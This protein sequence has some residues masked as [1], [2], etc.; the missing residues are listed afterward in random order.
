MLQYKDTTL[1]FMWTGA[2][3]RK[4]YG[5]HYRKYLCWLNKKICAAWECWVG[6]HVWSSPLVPLAPP[7]QNDAMLS[8]NI[9]T[10]VDYVDKLL[11]RR[12]V[13]PIDAK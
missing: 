2:Y 1:E 7:R 3:L 9:D 10:Y 12:N 5:K 4:P 8:L 11:I 13:I 6:V